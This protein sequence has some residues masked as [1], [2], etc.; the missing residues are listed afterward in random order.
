MPEGLFDKAEILA[1]LGEVADL[2][3]S[4]RQSQ[5][6][7][8][9]VGGSYLVLHDLRLVGTRDVDSI[10]RLT[11]AVRRAVERV[12]AENDLSSNWLNDRAAM[13]VPVGFERS[14]CT[15]LFE[16]EALLVL[17]PTPDWV[18]LMK[19]HAAREVDRDDMVSLWPRC[20]FSSPQEAA[21]R[22]SDAYPHEEDDPYLADYISGLAAAGSGGAAPTPGP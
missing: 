19:L 8:I 6:T 21:A 1:H 2:L 3:V 14:D 17:G 4:E 9:V 11:E 16:H 20:R 22:Y 13:F 12:A 18:F 15:V 10:E 7:L 5:A